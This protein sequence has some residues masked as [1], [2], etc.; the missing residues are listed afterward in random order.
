M[1]F[2]LWGLNFLARAAPEA[3][4]PGCTTIF[5]WIPLF[6]NDAGAVG[7]SILLG[8]HRARDHD[9]ADRRR[10]QPRGV[11]QVPQ[12][13]REAALALG[14]TKLEMIRTAVLPF[15]RPGV[16][17]AIMLG[18]GRAL[19]ETIAIALV[20]VRVV[21]H[22]D[23][24]AP[25]T[26]GN[27][28]AAN[29]ATKFGEADPTGRGA[30]IATGLVLFV[31]TLVVNMVA[32]GDHLPRAASSDEGRRMSAA[33]HRRRAEPPRPAAARRAGLPAWAAARRRDLAL[34]VLGG[35]PSHCPAAAASTHRRR[36]A[37]GACSSCSD[38]RTVHASSKA[39]ARPATGCA[40]GCCTARSCSRW[41]P[42][43]SVVVHAAS[44]G[45]RRLDAV[46]P[47]HSMHDIG[48]FDN[49]G[50]AYHAMVGTLE[51][52]VSPR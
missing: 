41:H 8:Q 48:P 38:R 12:A 39:A 50:G 34:I 1:V 2:G 52:V 30:L 15:G 47:Q 9:P 11:P 24:G 49:G 44:A 16:I 21:R 46:L 19:G 7:R 4:R 5:G 23:P 29:I 43:L 22:L 37:G 35:R 51:Q 32:R 17:S 36:V 27:T 6:K 13:N 10:H 26:G 20:L 14:A 45:H 40:T 42:L 33:V 3:C 18:L 28:I 31:I 25:A